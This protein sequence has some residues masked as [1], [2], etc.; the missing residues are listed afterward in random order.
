MNTL[1]TEISTVPI[2]IR[3]WLINDSTGK[4]SSGFIINFYFC[5]LLTKIIINTYF[6]SSSLGFS[7]R[8]FSTKFWY[9]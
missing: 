4:Q 6:L 1:N 3:V 8:I 9:K 5:L 7:V 2:L